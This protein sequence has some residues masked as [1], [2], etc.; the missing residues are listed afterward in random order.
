M[1][2]YLEQDPLT[3]GMPRLLINFND[4]TNALSLLPPVL[5]Q[6]V[7]NTLL[8]N[9]GIQIM[10]FFSSQVTL[11][12]AE[13]LLQEARSYIQGHPALNFLLRDFSMSVPPPPSNL[14][15]Q[16]ALQTILNSLD[17]MGL[18][19]PSAGRKLSQVW[20]V[21]GMGNGR[22]GSSN[23]QRWEEKEPG[24]SCPC[25]DEAGVCGS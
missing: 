2:L 15:A 12:E 7:T 9:S 1:P 20:I 8:V 22:A 25:W 13:M 18:N 14:S 17:A 10:D 5:Q 19:V 4:T 24:G 11:A 6:Y 16:A 23:G 21:K 3:P